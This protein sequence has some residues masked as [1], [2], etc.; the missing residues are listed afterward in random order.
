MTAESLALE[1]KLAAF[2]RTFPSM[3][4]ASGVKL[5]D[6]NTL[7]LWATESPI[8]PGELATAQFLLAIWDPTHNWRCGRFDLMD[9]L[10]LWDDRHRAAFLAWAE[11]PWWA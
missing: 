7:D 4:K 2:A 5:W 8:S 1:E 9:A 10:K 6:A 3:A 11:E